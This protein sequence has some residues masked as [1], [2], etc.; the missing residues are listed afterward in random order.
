MAYP[1]AMIYQ[2]SEAG[3]ENL[4]LEE[5][6]AYKETKLFYDDPKRMLHYLLK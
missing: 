5:T 4:S 6:L 1:E 2:F 3:L